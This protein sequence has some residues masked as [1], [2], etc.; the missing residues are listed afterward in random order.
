MLRRG[1]PETSMKLR[2]NN[3]FV[4]SFLFLIDGIPLAYFSC[5]PHKISLAFTKQTKPTH[6]RCIRSILLLY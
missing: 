2:K 5:R 1:Q 4:F 6:F 3:G